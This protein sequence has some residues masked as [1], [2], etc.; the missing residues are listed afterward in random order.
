MTMT[1]LILFALLACPW[2]ICPSLTETINHGASSTKSF[3]V[4][5]LNGS[6]Q[7]TTPFQTERQAEYQVAMHRSLLEAN[8][9]SR[10]GVS[11]CDALCQANQRTA[12]TRLFRAWNGSEW[13]RRGNWPREDVPLC[14][15]EGILCC[16]PAGLDETLVSDC[17]DSG[18][19]AGIRLESNNMSGS[20]EDVPWSSLAP[21]LTLLV[22][23]GNNLTGS[24]GALRPLSRLAY[25]SVSENRL[26]GSVS[27]LVPDQ[28]A[29]GPP[30]GLMGLVYLMLPANQLTGTLPVGL[31]QHPTLQYVDLSGNALV[32]SLPGELFTG[33]NN[34]RSVQLRG[35]RLSGN[36][37]DILPMAAMVEDLTYVDVSSN[38]LTGTL[39][40]YLTS[41]AKLTHL[42]ASNN[43]LTG[44]VAPLLRASLCLSY[45]ALRN[46]S[47]NGTVPTDVLGGTQLQYLDLS[48]NNI[49]GTLPPVFGLH[50][51]T[52]LLS[53]NTNLTGELPPGLSS[54]ATLDISR[55]GMQAALPGAVGLPPYLTLSNSTYISLGRK[56]YGAPLCP[57]A[58]LQGG[59]T[60]VVSPYYWQY[61]GCTCRNDY[62]P[63]NI[64]DNSSSTSAAAAT[65]PSTNAAVRPPTIEPSRAGGG[66]GSRVVGMLCQPPWSE[67]TPK[68][69]PVRFPWWAA[70]M[71]AVGGLALA[72]SLLVVVRRLAP[73]VERY[74]AIISKRMPPGANRRGQNCMVTLVLTDVEGSTELWEWD[75]D[76]MAAAIEL[77]DHTLRFNLSKWQGYEVQTEGDAF[78][79]A[80]HEP[81]D[82]LGWCI[83]SQLLLLSADWDPEL[84][85]H[86]KASIETIDSFQAMTRPQ[87]RDNPSCNNQ[88]QQLPP[89]SMLLQSHPHLLPHM[90]SQTQTQHPQPPMAPQV[91]S[92]LP[93]SQRL[94][95]QSQAYLQAQQSPQLQ[96]QQ[97][98]QQQQNQE[99][100]HH[101][102]QHQEQQHQEQ[103]QSSE[104]APQQPQQQLQPPRVIPQQDMAFLQPGSCSFTMLRHTGIVLIGD[105]PLPTGNGYSN[106][107]HTVNSVGDGGPPTLSLPLSRPQASTLFG[108]AALGSGE[109]GCSG[110]DATVAPATVMAVDMPSSAAAAPDSDALLTAQSPYSF[111]ERVA[112]LR[113]SNG[114]KPGFAFTPHDVLAGLGHA[115]SNGGGAAASNGVAQ[116][117]S[118]STAGAEHKPEDIWSNFTRL[119]VIYRG[120][121]VRMGVATGVTDYLWNNARMEYYGEVRRRLQAVADLPQGGQIFIDASTFNATRSNLTALS[122]RVQQLLCKDRRRPRGHLH[123]GK[124]VSVPSLA[125]LT[126]MGPRGPVDARSY[127][128][129]QLRHPLDLATAPE[130]SIDTDRGAT[131][132]CESTG[133]GVGIFGGA[134]AGGG[135]AGGAVGGSAAADP[136][137]VAAMQDSPLRS[138]DVSGSLGGSARLLSVLGILG[139]QAARHGQAMGITAG[140]SASGGLAPALQQALPSRL[141][142][143]LSRFTGAPHASG[144][145]TAAGPSAPPP[146]SRCNTVTR[147]QLQQQTQQQQLFPQ[148]LV[149]RRMLGGLGGADTAAGPAATASAF[150]ATAAGAGIITSPAAAA[151]AGGLTPLFPQSNGPETP[152]S[153]SGGISGGGALG[154]GS[155]PL[156]TF[157]TETVDAPGNGGGGLRTLEGSFN[158]GMSSSGLVLAGRSKTN[159]SGGAIAP[160]FGSCQGALT[161]LQPNGSTFLGTN[162]LANAGSAVSCSFSEMDV[163]APL[164]M[165]VDAQQSSNIRELQLSRAPNVPSTGPRAAN[166]NS[167]CPSAYPGTTGLQCATITQGGGGIS[168]AAA[169]VGPSSPAPRRPGPA[170]AVGVMAMGVFELQAG[171]SVE[172]VSLTQVLVPGL[173]ERAR[174]SRHLDDSR[175][176]TPGYLDAPAATAAPLGQQRGGPGSGQGGCGGGGTG[177]AGGGAGVNAAA[178]AS[179]ASGIIPQLHFRALQLPPVAVVFCSMERY[180]EMIAVS[181]DLSYDVLSVYN[182]CVRRS[183]LACSGYECQ[184]Q[185][186]HFMVAFSEPGAALEWCLMLQELVMEVAWTP[187]MLCLP[188]MQEQ[189]HPLTGAVLF[190][191][192]RVKAG[193]YAGVPTRVGPH[194]TTGRADYYGPLVNRAARFC[195]AAAQGGQVIVA[196]SLLEDILREDLGLQEAAFMMQQPQPQQR[197]Q[198]S[199]GLLTSATQSQSLPLPSMGLPPS[200]PSSPPP[201]GAAN[202]LLGSSLLSTLPQT[203]AIP[204]A[205]AAAAL[206]EILPLR[207]LGYVN[208]S[209]VAPSRWRMPADAA[210]RSTAGGECEDGGGEILVYTNQPVPGNR[211]VVAPATSPLRRL[212]PWSRSRNG[213]GGP[214]H[215]A[216]AGQSATVTLSEA[217]VGSMVLEG[218]SK[219]G[220]SRQQPHLGN[221]R[222]RLCSRPMSFSTMANSRPRAAGADTDIVAANGSG[223][224]LG[225]F[226][227][228][229][230][231]QLHVTSSVTVVGTAPPSDTITRSTSSSAG[232]PAA[233]ASP[234][235]P[236]SRPPSPLRPLLTRLGS[237]SSIRPPS[238]AGRV[239][240][241]M[242]EIAAPSTA[243][244]GANSFI[245]EEVGIAE[246]AEYDLNPAS[247]PPSM[248]GMVVAAA[249]L[250]DN[251][252]AAAAAAAAATVASERQSSERT[253]SNPQLMLQLHQHQHHHQHHQHHHHHHHHSHRNQLGHQHPSQVQLSHE[254]SQQNPQQQQQQQNQ[255]QHQSQQR[256]E[257]QQQEPQ[258]QS[259]PQHSHPEP[260]TH[261]ASSPRLGMS[262]SRLNN[263][264]GT[265][266]KRVPASRNARFRRMST[267]AWDSVPH[268][269]PTLPEACIRRRTGVFRWLWA[270]ELLVEDLGLFRFKGVAGSHQL[271]SVSTAA[272]SERRA[273]PR[274]HTAKGERVELGRGPLYR[275]VLKAVD[276]SLAN[277]LAH[278]VPSR[279][280]EL[281][282]IPASGDIG[283]T[284]GQQGSVQVQET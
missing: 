45:L 73:S 266:S 118:P 154:A 139:Q 240:G 176:L 8:N 67:P 102:Q 36:L 76:V 277:A 239:T 124:V 159:G 199:Q 273:G 192:P 85:R 237:L 188:G 20:L 262:T 260:Q 177:V 231:P 41:R 2:F 246:L 115:S 128:S 212:T 205:T 219:Q 243:V 244:H 30:G 83:T 78:L 279:T 135:G 23:D 264:G 153:Y 70:L 96:Y 113:A 33:P 22:L 214:G 275:V 99:Q 183:L 131:T 247:V 53:E 171:S 169:A 220:S 95:S 213:S 6:I 149:S 280:G 38:A 157:V 162:V 185:E 15:W 248:R 229:S 284:E 123:S 17:S 103:H 88:S 110:N 226:R 130:P 21:T 122:I 257:L 233:M 101:H 175:Q 25:L 173:E 63:V 265:S 190:K 238:P 46:N 138:G 28:A 207:L 109:A 251:R 249:L 283:G 274:L 165:F 209:N 66:S 167:T 218:T 208:N 54:L 121:R 52:L 5:V 195:H 114:P 230:H 261:P 80:F 253:P 270:H 197:Q 68:S 174:L 241:G 166:V 48:Q 26:S 216:D 221:S 11:A 150:S 236:R 281:S 158:A 193:L 155:N 152:G 187:P 180:S 163:T 91:P 186:G 79:V 19:V 235:A 57:V 37:P 211:A 75:T 61:G 49:G 227:T 147:Y 93:P 172:Y 51:I 268:T 94:C 255:N 129:A 224:R 134:G 65:A 143:G 201:K 27:A 223:N 137:N 106:E 206:P 125:C 32:G 44:P 126:S 256:Q 179:N 245:A 50:L 92:L 31:L 14:Q 225:I 189:L 69:R 151:A 13:T 145:P 107:Q 105:P 282:P 117:M 161:E 258:M 108:G 18:T 259:Q 24:P 86:V 9:D 142:S 111:A 7:E 271:V 141:A 97:K 144:T 182:D 252:R 12:L 178:L 29:G 59:Q 116:P 210:M 39:P 119:G 132:G 47:L 82:A 164:G 40:P 77:H 81:A 62:V 228:G 120:L 112:T 202:R 84:F 72:A 242:I 269:L 35:N 170:L 3:V 42:D 272:T 133:G 71:L 64:T 87:S 267:V 203:A 232:Q 215:S 263:A 278:L 234:A 204:V 100:Q 1:I 16:L 168:T 276:P 56:D 160:G 104:Q 90:Q 4:K 10:S 140:G 43:R 156:R 250:G 200:L 148:L 196:R 55:T 74:R 198:Q 181:R 194:P 184:E 34:L 89:L 146:W 191:G 254:P 217:V 222:R 136:W 60:A 98:Y 58:L 127:R